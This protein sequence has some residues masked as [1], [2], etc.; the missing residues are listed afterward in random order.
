MRLLHPILL[1][2][3]GIKITWQANLSL[4]SSPVVDHQ[5]SNMKRLRKH[6]KIEF[7]GLEPQRN[8]EGGLEDE[9]DEEENAKGG[10][11]RVNVSMG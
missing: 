4:K 2:V 5:R 1:Q 9:V 10:I 3:L 6:A 11:K 8:L 7:N